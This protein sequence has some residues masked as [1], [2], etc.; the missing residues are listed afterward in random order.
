L[1]DDTSNDRDAFRRVT[2]DRVAPTV[3]TASAFWFECAAQS[4]A[5]FSPR[6]RRLVH[7][8]VVRSAPGPASRRRFALRLL[9]RHDARCVGPTSAFS[10]LRT[11]T[12]ASPVPDASCAFAP[13]PRGDRLSHVSAIRFGG[14]HVLRGFIAAG[15]LFPSRCVRAEPLVFLSPPPRPSRRSRGVL[16]RGSRRD[17]S[18]PARVNDAG[19]RYDPGHLPSDKDLRPATLSRAPGSGLSRS[20]GLAT[21]APVLDTFSPAAHPCG[22]RGR[23]G[24]RPRAP[25]P[26]GVTL[27][28]ASASLADFCNLFCDARAHPTSLR[29]S[30]ASGA[31]APLLAGTN[32]C[33]LRWPPRCVAAPGACEPRPAR[34]GLRTPRSTRVDGAGHGPKRSSEGEPRA[35]GRNRA[36]PPR[37]ASGTRVTVS[38]R[39]E[40]WRTRGLAAPA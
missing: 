8:H 24:P 39:L 2:T 30:H 6:S 16:G 5:P 10:R 13:A 19:R 38:V 36:C 34:D 37:G 23:P 1:R 14:P 17:R 31:F 40:V 27:L 7:Q 3:Q 9:V 22:W 33:R 35:L 18:Q 4:R 11:S 29:S 20:R 12:R 32:R 25:L 28:W 26:T 15:L 21:A